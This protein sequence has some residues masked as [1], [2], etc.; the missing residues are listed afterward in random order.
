MSLTKLIVLLL[1]ANIPAL[2]ETMDTVRTGSRNELVMKLEKEF[3]GARVEVIAADGKILA[4]N[5]LQR[6]RLVI[7][8]A[9]PQIG[10]YL[11]RFTKGSLK[12][13]FMYSSN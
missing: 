1:L 7:V 5:S 11:V 4:V 10:S 8:F 3:L 6:R 2:A 12:Q 13:E 9:E